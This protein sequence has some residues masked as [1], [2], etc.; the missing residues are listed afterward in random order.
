M[1]TQAAQ[2]Q[3]DRSGPGP[4]RPQRRWIPTQTQEV[5]LPAR[6]PVGTSAPPAPKPEASATG[7]QRRKS[8]ALGLVFLQTLH[9]PRGGSRRTEHRVREPPG[10]T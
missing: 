9:R 8:A 2:T 7:A 6:G 1:G 10:T 3:P 4:L 5:D